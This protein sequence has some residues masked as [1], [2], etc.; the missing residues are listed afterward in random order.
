MWK[1][2]NVLPLHKKDNRTKFSN[3]RPISLPSMVSKICEKLVFK[4]L[5]NYVKDNILISL[6]QSDFTS[7]DSTF[8]QLLYLYDTFCKALD[9]KKDVRIVF[10][11]QSKAFDRV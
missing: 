5:Y 9:E 4:H 8:Y 6:H 7:G 3:Y 1:D 10:C 2:A 11:D